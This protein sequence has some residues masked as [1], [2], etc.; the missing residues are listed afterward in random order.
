MR[1]GDEPRIPVGYESVYEAAGRA[2]ANPEVLKRKCRAG[3][4]PGAHKMPGRGGGLWVVP[5]GARLPPD[6]RRALNDRRAREVA[7]RA[8]AGENKAALAHKFGVDRSTVYEWMDR[9]PPRESKAGG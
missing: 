9:Y 6:R 7:Q 5:E 2:G 1:R 4:V 8:R 3:E